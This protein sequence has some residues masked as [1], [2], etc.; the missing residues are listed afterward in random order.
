MAR[1][2]IKRKMYGAWAI[3]HNI[4]VGGLY[5]RGQRHIFYAVFYILYM[6]TMIYIIIDN[7]YN[8]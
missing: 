2:T 3:L 4:V 1:L 8:I 7:M 6:L 5:S